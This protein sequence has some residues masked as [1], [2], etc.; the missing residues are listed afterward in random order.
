LLY[1]ILLGGYFCRKKVIWGSDFS[2]L[3]FVA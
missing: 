2:E 1:Y 3:Y